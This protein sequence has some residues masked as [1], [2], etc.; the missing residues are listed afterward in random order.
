MVDSLLK[1]IYQSEEV[2]WCNVLKRIIDVVLILGERDLAF[3]GSSHRIGDLDNGNILGLI[4]MLSWWGPMLQEHVQNVK[5]YQEKGERH[6]VYYLSPESNDEFISASSSLMKQ[7]ILLE[8]IISIYFAV[9]VDVTPSSSLVVQTTFLLRH[10]NLED[11]RYEVPERFLMF[12]NCSSER[13]EDIAQ[14]IMDALE[15]HAIPLSD[16]MPQ[17]YDN[18]ANMAGNY[19]GAHAKI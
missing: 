2:K 4:E 7:N 9:I 1:A 16:C 6:Q 3:S 12:T 13:E 17:G 14:L 19:K 15:E 10:S 11:D 8:R 5:E 18:A